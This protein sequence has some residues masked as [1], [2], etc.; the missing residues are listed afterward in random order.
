MAGFSFYPTKNLGAM[1]DAGALTTEDDKIA[2]L[3][4]SFRAHGEQKR[5][6]ARSYHYERVGR[7]SRMDGFQ[8]AVLRVKLKK[9]PEW[10][11]ARIANAR[12]FDRALA[13][14]DGVTPPP[15]PH[16][17]KHVYH[18]YAIRAERRDELAARLAERG[19]ETRV[20]YPEPLHLA[21][22]LADLGLREGQFPEAE[23]AAAEVLSLP[24]HAH[25]SPDDRDRIVAEMRAFYGA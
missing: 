7:N 23:R 10:H 24:V 6:G 25:L 13:G 1:G 22:A 14:I 5:E 21:P 19:I 3:A 4:R 11:D 17:G 20:F 18:Q 12:F 8:A 15:P 2:A 9:L 16:D